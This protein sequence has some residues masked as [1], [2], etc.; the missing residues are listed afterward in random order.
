MPTENASLLQQQ[1][2]HH[3]LPHSLTSSLLFLQVLQSKRPVAAVK[4][5]TFYSNDYPSPHSAWIW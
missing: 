3:T 2:E 4:R 5:V 1:H